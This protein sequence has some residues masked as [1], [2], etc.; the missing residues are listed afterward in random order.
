MSHSLRIGSSNAKS[1]L[2]RRNPSATQFTPENT[3]LSLSVTGVS[4]GDIEQCVNQLRQLLQPFQTKSAS[5][6][7]VVGSGSHGNH[8]YPIVDN[9]NRPQA[10]LDNTTTVLVGEHTKAKYAALRKALDRT[11]RALANTSLSGLGVPKWYDTLGRLLCVI[12]EAPSWFTSPELAQA[13]LSCYFAYARIRPGSN[14]E[15]L[16]SNDVRRK[17]FT[18]MRKRLVTPAV[19]SPSVLCALDAGGQDVATFQIRTL[20]ITWNLIKNR[21]ETLKQS[22]RTLNDRTLNKL[23]RLGHPLLHSSY[24]A[25]FVY[26]LLNLVEISSTRYPL[27]NDIGVSCSEFTALLSDVLANH[28][29]IYFEHIPRTHRDRLRDTYDAILEFDI[30]TVLLDSFPTDSHS[31]Q[32]MALLQ[33]HLQ[34]CELWD[35]LGQHPRRW[36]AFQRVCLSLLRHNP[37]LFVQRWWV[38]VGRVAIRDPSMR[39]GFRD[40]LSPFA[41]EIFDALWSE[42]HSPTPTGFQATLFWWHQLY[43]VTNRDNDSCDQLIEAWWTLHLFPSHKAYAIRQL[44]I[45]E[46]TLCAQSFPLVLEWLSLLLQPC[47]TSVTRPIFVGELE[48]MVI[49]FRQLYTPGEEF[50]AIVKQFLEDCLQSE[51]YSFVFF[52]MDLVCYWFIASN[53]DIAEQQH[54]VTSV[55]DYAREANRNRHTLSAYSGADLRGILGSMLRQLAD[56]LEEDTTLVNLRPLVNSAIAEMVRDT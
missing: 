18:V 35:Y 48:E 31:Y 34:S 27:M 14:V 51:Q 45:A 32:S 50:R 22:E 3:N 17:L 4:N 47:A 25:P 30:L 52:L 42:I 39:P 43:N 16:E 29:E 21:L 9:K 11:C 36:K 54:W 37:T 7:T 33:P 6:Q 38:Y 53:E 46:P 19:L 10:T 55:L 1:R 41:G 12:G 23:C 20:G 5:T 26:H 56:F 2:L 24:G 15:P 13:I 40:S 49:I 44:Y 8:A 28:S